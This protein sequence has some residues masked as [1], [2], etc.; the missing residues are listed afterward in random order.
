MTVRVIL[1]AMPS[2]DFNDRFTTVPFKALSDW[3]RFQCLKSLTSDQGY[4]ARKLQ[5]CILCVQIETS[6]LWAEFVN[7][8]KCIS[9]RLVS[10]KDKEL[11]FENFNNLHKSFQWLEYFIDFYVKDGS[12]VRPWHPFCVYITALGEYTAVQKMLTPLK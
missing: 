5:L 11:N 12:H 6:T 1:S 3:I 2:K 9:V 4:N 8:N 10:E 7:K